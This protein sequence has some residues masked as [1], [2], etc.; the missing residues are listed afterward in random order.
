MHSEQSH[1][2]AFAK[3]NNQRKNLFK[4]RRVAVVVVPPV[5]EL[6]LVGPMQVF[7]AANRLAGMPVYAVTA[8]SG[9]TGV[10][11]SFSSCQ[12]NALL[13]LFQEMFNYW[14]HPLLFRK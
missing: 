8:L 13:R 3:C 10:I 7:S 4:R 14:D 1:A 12:R 9:F 6:D 2:S 5:E 11:A